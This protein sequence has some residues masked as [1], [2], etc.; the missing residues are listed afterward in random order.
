MIQTRALVVALDGQD[1][2]VEAVQGGCGSCSAANGC[3]SSKLSQMFCSGTRHFRVRNEVNARVGTF[4]QIAMPEGEL[5]HG[6]LLAYAMP[7]GL[8]LAGAITASA[9]APLRESADA[10]AAV[11]GLAGLVAGFALIKILSLRKGYVSARPVIVSVI[12]ND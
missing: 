1:A 7:L 6:A 3:G 2:M 10:Y 4:V 9:F 5:L 11:G 12:E 8:L